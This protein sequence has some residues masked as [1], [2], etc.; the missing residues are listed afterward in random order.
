MGKVVMVQGT[1][2]HAG[3]SV[4]AAALCRVFAQDGL[5]V[6]PFKA[7]NM[8]LNSF[9]TPD[10]GEIGRAQAMQAAAARVAP[11]VDMNP[12]LLKPEADHRSQ[13]VVQGRP[14]GVASV[15]EYQ[16]MK[17][18][19]WSTVTGAL[20][21]LRR[22]FDV[23]VIEGAGSPAEINLKQHDIVNMRV[24]LHAGAPV[25]LIADIDRGGVFA[26]LVGTMALLDPEEQA[27]VKAF[28]INK[29]R[30]DVSLLEPG[31][32]MLRDR[33]G[34]PVA[35][36]L[37][38]FTD[39]HL[40]EEDSLGLPPGAASRQ[41]GLDIAI[42]RLPH[43]ANFDD[44]DPLR[45]EPDVH[46]RYVSGAEDLGRPDLI[47]IPGSK[48][49][50]ADLDWL[51]ETGL[52]VRI[53]GLHSDGVPV[54]GICGGYQ[55]LGTRVHDPDGV[56]SNRQET[57]GLALLPASTVF[58]REKAVHQVTARVASNSGMLRGC[59]GARLSA[60]EIHMGVTTSDRPDAPFQIAS[61]SGRPADDPDGAI[62]SEG[63]T[64]G[65]YLHGL[66]HNRAFRRSVLGFLADSKGIPLSEAEA[67][68]DPD[69][70]YDKLA[71]FV[72]T[73]LDMALIRGIVGL[74]R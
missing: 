65:T 41:G 40:P 16:R 19:L 12:V 26:H 35:G 15:R 32:E 22:E 60:Y 17:G 20:D 34:V 73:H 46:L 31:L 24:A 42:V 43:I 8:S 69:H 1:S 36:V 55:M 48:T 10:G 9:A 33:T 47:V 64:L 58:S 63:K 49:T 62:D 45:W 68:I 14:Y 44:F 37:P 50:V 57:A 54:I 2:S 30:G 13:V 39:I 21:R 67:D 52:D 7:Q 66:F 38:Y 23:V 28:V 3:K 56:E 72:R 61:R 6:A 59:E 18:E 53:V 27:L 51:R 4:L 11:S 29:F 74:P 70:E 71:D 25:L 5:R